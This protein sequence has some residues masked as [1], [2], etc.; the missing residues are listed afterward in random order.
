[1]AKVSVIIPVYNAEQYMERCA[2]CLFGQTLP[3][4]EYIFIDDCSPDKSIEVMYSVLEQYPHRKQQ[5]KVIRNAQNLK[6]AGSRMAG[7]R[8]A[9][10]DYMIHCDPDD[11]VELDM[12]KSMLDLAQQTGSDVTMCDIFLERESWTRVLKMRHVTN[13]HE[14]INMVKTAQ[15][16]WALWNKLVKTSVIRD[17]DIYP[18]EGVNYMEDVGICVRVLYYANQIAYVDKPFYHYNLTNSGSICHD[19]DF[20]SNIAQ[21][22][23]CIEN[24]QA[25]FADKPE[26]FDGFLNAYKLIIKNEHLNM[27]PKNFSGWKKTFPELRS[28]IFSVKC[29]PRMMRLSMYC[30]AYG[31][32]WPYKLYDLT[33]RVICKIKSLVS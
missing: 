8:A 22:K 24:L 26:N 16:N 29:F 7:M 13:P 27:R 2:N 4:I 31:V 10:G 15:M 21:G 20:S 11:W 23:A 14:Y 5:V 33:R 9:T 1:M 3:D 25:F 18:F 6:Q 32:T 30:L 17:H 12:Y 19:R 28:Q